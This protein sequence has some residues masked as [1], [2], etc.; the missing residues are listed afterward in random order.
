VFQDRIVNAARALLI[1]ATLLGLAAAAA[2]PA[3]ARNMKTDLAIYVE[4]VRAIYS[5]AEIT[6]AFYD[7][8]SV[9]M[10]RSAAGLHLGYDIALYAGRAVP[11]GW[12]GRVVDV[13]PWSDG[14]WGVAVELANG[15]RV[16]YGHL[17][18]TVS[19]G[20]FVQPGNTVGTV[21]RDHV[22]I[23]VKDPSGGYF[24]FGQSYGVLDGSSPWVAGHGGLLPPPP[25]ESGGALPVGNSLESLYAQYKQTRTTY[26][27]RRI[28]RDRV[29]DLV[30]TLRDYLAGESRGLP[31]AEQQ[32][33]AWY[34]AA[35][36]NQLTHSQAEAFSLTVTS[37]RTRVNR[38]TYVLERR[39]QI[40]AEREIAL[41][42][43]E[44]AMNASLKALENAS[45][46]KARIATIESL[47]LSA[48]RK[49]SPSLASANVEEKA[50]RARQKMLTLKQRH[51]QGMAART[52]MEEAE[53]EYRRMHLV[54]ALYQHGDHTAASGL[55]Y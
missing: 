11:A 30:D 52:D 37:R 53:R 43:A 27:T 50:E 42:S 10:Y 6:G 1:G 18:P 44:R 54:E 51:A 7:W 8:R 33:L 48:A 21:V 3:S 23:K 19:I 55:D 47:S 5:E 32:V 2:Q 36:Q 15:Y 20:Q 34:R 45:P 49:A 35:D 39:L 17:S 28:E 4:R 22:D 29:A 12:P 31:Q 16:T 46:D 13:I 24:D 38:L 26:E 40:L 41:T 14:E 25:Y 9:S